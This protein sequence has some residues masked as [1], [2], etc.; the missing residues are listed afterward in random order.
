M[1]AQEAEIIPP[2]ASQAKLRNAKGKAGRT[3]GKRYR[4]PKGVLQPGLVPWKP[5]QSGNPL[6]LAAAYGDVI[7]AAREASPGALLRLIELIQS[8]DDRVAL[9][10][11]DKLLERAWGKPKEAQDDKA[12]GPPDL[13]ALNAGD[14]A[15]LRRIA[16]K[17]RA[18]D[19]PA[20]A[21]EAPPA[22]V[23]PAAA[24]IPVEE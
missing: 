4:P 16:G 9:M 22:R 13:G 10:A 7:R 17:M 24:D 15:E 12:A 6:G 18:Q 19:A 11:A 14:L 20:A 3:T 1:K 8:P 21:P 23:E 2:K 5:G